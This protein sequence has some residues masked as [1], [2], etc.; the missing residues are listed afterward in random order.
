[1]EW[2]GGIIVAL[3]VAV[4]GVTGWTGRKVS[5][6]DQ[7][8]KDKDKECGDHWAKTHEIDR[9]KDMLAREFEYR[10]GMQNGKEKAANNSHKHA[11]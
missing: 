11:V 7:W 3:L 9:E 6:L 4:L 10:K 1:M 2:I 5:A 8:T